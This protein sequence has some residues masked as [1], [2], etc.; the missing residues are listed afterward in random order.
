M[1]PTEILQIANRPETPKFLFGSPELEQWNRDHVFQGACFEHSGWYV[2]IHTTVHR[3][4]FRVL[5]CW[6]YGK[7]APHCYDVPAEQL[8]AA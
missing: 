6:S 3:A 1:T 4:A 7:R 8:S 2:V 5:S